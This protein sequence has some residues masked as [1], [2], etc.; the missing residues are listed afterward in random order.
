MAKQAMEDHTLPN[1][2]LWANQLLFWVV[3]SRSTGPP[4]PFLAPLP[5]PV[6]SP[7]TPRSPLPPPS[8]RP[9]PIPPSPPP[10]VPSPPIPPSPPPPVPPPPFPP[11]PPP[12]VPPPPPPPLPPPPPPALPAACVMETPPPTLQ[13]CPAPSIAV[14]DY[15]LPAGTPACKFSVPAKLDP[16]DPGLVPCTNKLFGIPTGNGS[17]QEVVCDYFVGD[18]YLGF[19]NLNGLGPMRMGEGLAI[20]G[21]N[22]LLLINGSLT[23][24]NFATSG[25]PGVTTPFLPN[26]RTVTQNITILDI[27]PRINRPLFFSSLPL[28]SV[29]IANVVIVSFGLVDMTSFSG[30]RYVAGSALCP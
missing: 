27:N 12:P 5:P 21:L 25:G 15:L 10:P 28:Q 9:P 30:L 16:T 24:I 19:Y 17:V 26:L 8:V 20:L 3:C 13:G 2:K 6:P 11:S 22:N 29:R 1:A 14:Y 4:A 23:I 7:P 18:L